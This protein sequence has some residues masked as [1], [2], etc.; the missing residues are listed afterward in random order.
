MNSQNISLTPEEHSELSRRIRSATINQRDG[1]RARVILL[2]AQGH[3]RVD[4]AG[5]HRENGNFRTISPA[6]SPKSLRCAVGVRMEYTSLRRQ[7]DYSPHV[8]LG[9][10][11]AF[12]DAAASTSTT[13]T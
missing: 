6:D 13:S 2:A 5:V 3:S 7:D 11:S 9:F 1:R 12:S 10:I 4:I 8:R